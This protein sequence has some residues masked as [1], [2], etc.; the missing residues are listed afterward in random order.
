[1]FIEKMNIKNYKKL[2]DV[3]VCL[4]QKQNLFIGPNNSGKTSAIE[5][6]VKFLTD[7]KAFNI[8]DVTIGNWSELDNLFTLYYCKHDEDGKELELADLYNRMMQLL[9]TLKVT[10]RI[11]ETELY[12]VKSLIPYL[13]KECEKVAVTYTYE[14]ADFE[15]LLLD[16]KNFQYSVNKWKEHTLGSHKV[17][18]EDLDEIAEDHWPSNFKSFLATDS[19][20]KKYFTIKYYISNPDLE[21]GDIYS[22]STSLTTNP[23]KNIVK[24]SVIGA[25]RG[26]IDSNED[27][28]TIDGTKINLNNTRKLSK[29]FSDYYSDYLNPIN[30]YSEKDFT[31][32][33]AVTNS[34]K[35][36]KQHLEESIKPIQKKMGDLGYP[37]FGS[38]SITVRPQINLSD[39]IKGE[40]SLLLNTHKDGINDEQY[41]LPEHNNGLGYQNLIAMFFKLNIFK[42]ERLAFG[43]ENEKI[44]EPL[45]L[46]LIEEPEAHLHAQAQKVFIDKAYQL[47][48][49]SPEE[50]DIDATFATQLLISTHSSHI[51]YK[52]DIDELI[53]FNRKLQDDVFSS[54]VISLRDV[55]LDPIA[56]FNDGGEQLKGLSNKKFVQKYLQLY[57]HDLF[58]A[59]AVILIEGVS[60]RILL[61][62][63]IRKHVNS[64]TSRYITILEVG[65]AYA[66]RFIPFL[67]LINRPTLIIT[68]IDSVKMDGTKTHVNIN[69]ELKSSNATINN[70][71]MRTQEER[72]L[73]EKYRVGKRV[74]KGVSKSILDDKLIHQLISKCQ[75]DKINYPIRLAYQYENYSENIYARTFEDAIALENF[76]MFRD[77]NVESNLFSELILNLNKLFKEVG[78]ISNLNIQHAE[79]LFTFVNA[80]NVKSEFALDLLFIDEFADDNF[81]KCP[82]YILEGLLWLE[83]QLKSERKTSKAEEEEV[84]ETV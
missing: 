77:L 2:K 57:E 23:L 42:Q 59:D 48:N 28:D 34:K 19:R 1:M 47:V 45:H 25:Q 84:Y 61:P 17:Q 21:D 16:Y 60:E 73:H 72:K 30:Q 71:F 18:S 9:P 22:E 75:E 52:A 4:S 63:L 40:A 79:Q 50:T 11:E 39:S 6:L 82:K 74:R 24:V 56:T 10:L 54:E 3:K 78:D 12:H 68:D 46:V 44:I 49:L 64:L 55:T 14:P 81:M 51:T 5:I 31:I 29:L 35:V 41:F 26:L 33:N 69:E 32:L 67:R 62:E 65:G 80:K 38:P 27:G 7:K 53:Y 37:G 36:F 13:N 8:Y 43:G 20:F 76:K 83:E 15:K 70:W 58:F 66:N